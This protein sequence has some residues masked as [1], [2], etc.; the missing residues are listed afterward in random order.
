MEYNKKEIFEIIAETLKVDIELIEN[1]DED[2]DFTIHGMN[3][4][5]AIRI[6]VK[7]EETYDFELNDEDLLIDRFNTPKKIFA[8]LDSY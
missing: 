1:M 6:I 2:E 3:S 4:I 7:L 5:S 8:M